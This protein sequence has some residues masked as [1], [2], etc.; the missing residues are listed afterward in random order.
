MTSIG[1]GL[2][3]WRMLIK[4]RCPSDVITYVCLLRPPCTAPPTRVG[5]NGTGVSYSTSSA[6]SRMGNGQQTTVHRDVEQFL[7]VARPAHLGAAS[8]R[9]AL[10]ASAG[11]SLQID[12]E[13]A[14]LVRLVGD[15]VAVRREL[16]VTLF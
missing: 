12:F 10:F 8:Y 6:V 16:P 14:R 13:S 1:E 4:N 15:P 11:K 7:A 9:D 5:N 3:S 2:T